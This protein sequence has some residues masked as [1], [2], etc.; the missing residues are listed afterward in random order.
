MTTS[1]ALKDMLQL[2]LNQSTT[3]FTA[4][5]PLLGHYAE[6][7]SMGIMTLLMEV[8]SRLYIDINSIE[9]NVE[10]FETFGALMTCIEL[11]AHPLKATA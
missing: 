11:A 5:T 9:L 4:Q 8:E 6:L 10:N 1:T 2:V 7:D 3:H